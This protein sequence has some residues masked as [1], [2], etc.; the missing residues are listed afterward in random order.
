MQKIKKNIAITKTP[1]R[2]SFV[3]GGTDMP[4]FYQQYGGA[5]LST[6]INRF[7]YVLVKVHEHF[8]EKY[9]LN[10]SETETTN[11]LKKIKNVRIKETLKYFGI[12]DP[13]YIST[14]AD[15]PSNSGL[16]S[17][18]AFLV[19]L[20]KAL[21]KIYGLNLNK[22]KISEIAFKIE[23]KVTRGSVGKQDH[24]IASYGGF[25]LIKYYKNKTLIKKLNISKKNIVKFNKNLI[26]LWTGKYRDASRNLV[27]QKNNYKKNYKH[28]VQ[29]NLLTKKFVMNIVKKK[30]DIN[31]LGK[32]IHETWNLKKKIIEK[33]FK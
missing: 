14:I 19:G 11:D 6:T 22:R 24:F 5:T 3:G 20:I 4:Y 18:S 32:L 26:F 25:K 2:V 29:I 21:N 33:N 27:S 8:E 9:R 28:L 31:K 15:I 16:G 10:Y 17:S 30:I 7:I 23:H 1:L 12:K 13:L